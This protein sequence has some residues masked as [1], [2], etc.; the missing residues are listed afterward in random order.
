MNREIKIGDL[1]YCHVRGLGL[2]FD[3]VPPYDME[4][5]PQDDILYSDT[6]SVWGVQWLT[7]NRTSYIVEHYV[8][9]YKDA[10][11]LL[12]SHGS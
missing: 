10:L 2:V 6:A 11:E 7:Q 4:T 8:F 1:L 3:C 5:A 12:M 9:E